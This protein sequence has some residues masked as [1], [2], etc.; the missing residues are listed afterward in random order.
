MTLEP[1]L[2]APIAVQ[3]HVATVVPAFLIGTWVL[4]ISRKGYFLHRILGATF[5][6]LMGTGMQTGAGGGGGGGAN[7]A[8][9]GP[10]TKFP[11]KLVAENTSTVAKVI[12]DFFAI[13]M[14]SAS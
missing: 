4:F 1:L 12:I 11:A 14:G 5:L 6:A 9:I 3:A 8:G 7:L 10:V 2:H 13:D